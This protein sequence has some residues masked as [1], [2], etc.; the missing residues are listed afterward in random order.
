MRK[1]KEILRQKWL[2]KRSNRALAASAGF[3]TTTVCDTERRAR[4]A[5]L[6]W[7]DVA[8]LSEEALEAR[9]SI[10]RLRR[11]RISATSRNGATSTPSAS[12]PA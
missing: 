12:G 4:A 10:R 2:L 9:L 6:T 8:E 3:G 5:R 7:A 1:T 11:R